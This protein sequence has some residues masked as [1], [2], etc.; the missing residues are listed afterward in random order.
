MQEEDQD[1]AIEDIW[2]HVSVIEH[3]LEHLYA[4]QYSHAHNSIP[5]VYEEVA[6]KLTTSLDSEYPGMD[7]AKLLAFK[8]QT[9]KIL[10]E[11]IQKLK[12]R[13]TPKY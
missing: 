5:A 4:Q 7:E 1:K 2:A 13:V 3:L 9:I 6:R 10:N 12:D 11:F 8:H